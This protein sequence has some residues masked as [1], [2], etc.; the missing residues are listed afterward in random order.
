MT[1]QP[2]RWRK[3]SYTHQQTAC[4]EVGRLGSGAAVRDSKNRPAGYVE[5]PPQA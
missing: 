3:S 2:S 1:V 5:V 4:V